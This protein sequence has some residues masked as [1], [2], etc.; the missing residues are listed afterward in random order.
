ME[1]EVL[2]FNINQLLD[3]G[4]SKEE[5]LAYNANFCAEYTFKN[6]TQN[7]VNATLAFPLGEYSDFGYWENGEGG[8]RDKYVSLDEI[9]AAKN[10]YK[11][12]VDGA[13]IKA[14]TRYTFHELNDFDFSS[15]SKRICEGYKSHTF[16]SPDTPV[17][18]YTVRII[19]EEEKADYFNAETVVAHDGGLRFGGEYG[20]LNKEKNGTQITYSIA[21]NG[22]EI[23]MY[24]I[25][26]AVDVA[27][28]EWRFYK[29]ADRWNL[30]EKSVKARAVASDAV[31]QTT[32]KDYVL[33]GYSGATTFPKRKKATFITPC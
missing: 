27:A 2:T 1:S 19:P 10:M 12:L 24:S 26:G 11:V 17:Y 28:L 22:E 18:K 30:V 6:P 14:E 31:E 9:L 21:E 13:Q 23:E 16:F 4:L 5:L 20:S 33:K 3:S 32:F 15:E 29:Y 7:T 25:G 8:E